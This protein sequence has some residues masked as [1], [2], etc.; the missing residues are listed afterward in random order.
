MILGENKSIYSLIDY[1]IES[2]DYFT[3]FTFLPYRLFTC[4][5]IHDIFGIMKSTKQCKKM[6][7]KWIKKSKRNYK[8]NKKGTKQMKEN[9]CKQ[10]LQKG[11][12]IQNI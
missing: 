3:F 1:P 11:A 10:Y 4:F 12:N 9:I 8:Q 5:Y 6:N 7:S 2:T